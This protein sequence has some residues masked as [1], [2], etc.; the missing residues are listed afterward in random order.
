MAPSAWMPPARC[1]STPGK[2]GPVGPRTNNQ[3]TRCNVHAEPAEAPPA[4]G[5]AR[6][7]S[8]AQAPAARHAAHVP[9]PAC[10]LPRPPSCCSPSGALCVQAIPTAAP[11]QAAGADLLCVPWGERMGRSCGVG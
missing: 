6:L 10:R 2:A 5:H 4:K 3:Y 8:A 1:C 9:P 7:A 11:P